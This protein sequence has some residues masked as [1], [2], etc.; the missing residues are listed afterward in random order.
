[1]INVALIDTCVSPWRLV[2]HQL[3]NKIINANKKVMQGKSGPK[4]VIIFQFKNINL[5]AVFFIMQVKGQNPLLPY[6]CP[7]M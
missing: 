3:N 2:F 7:N 1:M 5:N 6:Y 4:K